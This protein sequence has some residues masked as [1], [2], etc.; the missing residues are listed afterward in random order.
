MKSQFTNEKAIGQMLY[1]LNRME[2]NA[3]LGQL[4]QELMSEKDD[5]TDAKSAYE[6]VKKTG[7]WRNFKYLEKSMFA[8]WSI[9]NPYA[10][11]TIVDI[12]NDITGKKFTRYTQVKKYFASRFEK[13]KT[14]YLRN[15]SRIAYDVYLDKNHIINVDECRLDSKDLDNLLLKN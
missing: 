8:L 9:T 10:Q 1:Y 14:K 2:R 6:L 4:R 5:I 7:S 15:V 13:W 11:K 3:Y 12:T